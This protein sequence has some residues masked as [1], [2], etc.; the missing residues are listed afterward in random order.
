MKCIEGRGGKLTNLKGSKQH[1]T[2]LCGGLQLG[3][4][5]VLS[6]PASGLGLVHVCEG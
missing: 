1:V 3:L 4:L 5:L 2:V 6:A